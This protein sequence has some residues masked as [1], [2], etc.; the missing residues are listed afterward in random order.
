MHYF[1]NVVFDMYKEVDEH[2][3]FNFPADDASS[4]HRLWK[5]LLE[6]YIHDFWNGKNTFYPLVDINVVRSAKSNTASQ[7][8]SHGP[9][10]TKY[11]GWYEWSLLQTLQAKRLN[12]TCVAM[13]IGWFGS[14][15]FKWRWLALLW[16]TLK[17]WPLDW[18][19]LCAT[20][21]WTFTYLAVFITALPFS[22][23]IG[24]ECT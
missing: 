9:Q 8:N 24:L 18:S 6:W 22:E 21:V 4:Q 13:W 3:S 14:D 19:C 15:I 11:V 2:I 20:T 5:C 1:G 10:L 17:R 12:T 23:Q 7:T 16:S